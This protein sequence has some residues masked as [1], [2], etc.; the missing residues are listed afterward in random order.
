MDNNQGY[1]TKRFVGVNTIYQMIRGLEV[2]QIASTHLPPWRI[3]KSN[4]Q[5]VL[6][7]KRSY[8]ACPDLI[9]VFEGLLV[10]RRGSVVLNF[11]TG[12]K[13][14]SNLTGM[15]LSALKLYVICRT[16]WQ[17]ICASAPK[18]HVIGNGIH[19]FYDTTYTRATLLRFDPTSSF[20]TRIRRLA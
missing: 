17:P 12:R 4:L 18:V 13:A 16:C 2:V 20:A 9:L 5:R 3:Q 7:D 15:F 19:L 6:P 11:F 14:K 10:S 1:V 8:D